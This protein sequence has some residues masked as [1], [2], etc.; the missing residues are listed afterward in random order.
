MLR[1]RLIAMNACIR[2]GERILMVESDDKREIQD[3]A[4]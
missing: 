1:G 2:K 4:F 3:K